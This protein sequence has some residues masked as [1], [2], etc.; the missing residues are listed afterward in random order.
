MWG[1]KLSTAETLAPPERRMED[2]TNGWIP[3]KGDNLTMEHGISG[4]ECIHIA[5]RQVNHVDQ[6]M[7]THVAVSPVHSRQRCITGPPVN[8]DNLNDG[9]FFTIRGHG[10]IRC[11][12]FIDI[13]GY[14]FI[15]LRFE[16]G[17]IVFVP[18]E[19]RFRENDRIVVDAS[20]SITFD[21][22]YMYV[23]DG[24][25]TTKTWLFIIRLDIGFGLSTD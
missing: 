17:M 4:T 19:P 15:V 10:N 25:V 18:L 11:L 7:N 23:T 2:I 14:D 8:F 6:G 16:L 21:Q 24:G 20:A 1:S 22:T 9:Q 5:I 3:F 12:R 13:G